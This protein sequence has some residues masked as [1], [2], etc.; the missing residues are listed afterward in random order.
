MMTGRKNISPQIETGSKIKHRQRKGDPR[1]NPLLLKIRP[2]T[3][4]LIVNVSMI[5]NARKVAS[6]EIT[7]GAKDGGRIDDLFQGDKRK[8]RGLRSDGIFG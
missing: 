2:A 3:E 5:R 8:I 7:M 4:E 6:L 1:M